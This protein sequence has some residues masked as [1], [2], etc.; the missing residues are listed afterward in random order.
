MVQ[1]Q[2]KSVIPDCQANL[3]QKVALQKFQV[4]A[5]NLFRPSTVKSLNNLTIR[6]TTYIIIFCTATRQNRN[7]L[8]R[9][10][11]CLSSIRCLTCNCANVNLNSAQIQLRHAL[12]QKVKVCVTTVSLHYC[13]CSFNPFSPFP[14]TVQEMIDATSSQIQ[15]THSC[16]CS[17]GVLLI[18][19][20]LFD[21]GLIVL[22]YTIKT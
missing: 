12:C 11:Q 15:V 19:G 3:H 17:R 14:A 7:A 22:I 20:L 4:L 10:Y 5:P 13:I 21:M 18:T 8:R 9:T 6:M 2:V 1:K 16:C